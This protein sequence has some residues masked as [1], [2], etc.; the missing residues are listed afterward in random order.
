MPTLETHQ[1]TTVLKMLCVGDSGSGKTGA[2]AS[3][4]N[5][6]YRLV[7]MDFDNGLDVL[8]QY[9]KPECRKNVIFKTFTDTFKPVGN[10]LLCQGAKAY[11]DAITSL[12]NWKDPDIGP[13]SSWGADTILVV[14]SLTFFGDSALRFALQLN[15]RLNQRPYQ[16]DWGEAIGYQED[17]CRLLY[18]TDIKCHVIM[19]AHLTS[20][21]ESLDDKGQPVQSEKLYPSALGNKLPPK[22]GRYFNTM[23]L[24]KLRGTQRKILTRPQSNV[25]V[26]TP[27]KTETL[28]SELPV[29]DGLL[30]IFKLVSKAAA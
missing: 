26:K 11:V 27:W 18:S 25:D 2:L 1:A 7:I 9:V 5:A 20:T 16:S 4:A 28:P 8:L 29:E 30:T 14:D 12:Q 22:I 13:A 24:F 21:R 15:Q 19:N 6:G 17:L 3:L 10:K 23:V